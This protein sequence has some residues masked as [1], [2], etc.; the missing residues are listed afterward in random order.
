MSLPKTLSSPFACLSG[1]SSSCDDL[2]EAQVERIPLFLGQHFES[3]VSKT[4]RPE[5]LVT[6]FTEQHKMGPDIKYDKS[7]FLHWC[8]KKI[9][10]ISGV[11]G[12][13][14]F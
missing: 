4:D 1:Y 8:L 14:G 6:V 2:V 3:K 9:Q 13:D 12:F 7:C 10:S 11:S 5:D